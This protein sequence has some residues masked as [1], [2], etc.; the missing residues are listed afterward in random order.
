MKL[1]QVEFV[2]V[3]LGGFY[4]AMGVLHFILYLYNRHRKSFFVY[5]IGLILV[6]INFTLVKLPTEEGFTLTTQKA[7]DVISS[8]TNGVLLYFVSYYLFASTAPKLRKVIRVFA[9]FYSV[10]FLILLLSPVESNHFNPVFISLKFLSYLTAISICVFGLLKRTQNFYLIVSAT[11][12]L[13]ITEAF[14]AKDLFNFWSSGGVPYPIERNILI[15]VGYAVPFIAYSAYTSKDL[16]LTSK[17]LSRELMMNEK[18]SKEK[19]EQELVTRKLLEVQNVELER[20]VHERT[21][22]ISKQKEELAAQADKIIELDKI[23]SRFFANISHEFRTP[24]TLILGPLSKRLEK[25][26]D[27][28]E[29]QELSVMQRNASRLLNL[30]NQLLDLSKLEDGSLRLKVRLD[31]FQQFFTSVATQFSSAADARKINFMVHAVDDVDMYFDPDKLHKILTNLLSNAFKFTPSGGAITFAMKKCAS[32]T[33]F[34]SGFVEVL[35]M[36]TGPGIDPEHMPHIFNRFYQG[37]NGVTREYEGSGIGLALTKELVELHYGEIT[38]SSGAGK[39]TC[40]V[41]Q[42]PLGKEHL[43]EHE[44]NNKSSNLNLNA[45]VEDLSLFEDEL[46]DA[47]EDQALPKILIVEDNADMRHYLQDSLKTNFHIIE[48][49]DGAEGVIRAQSHVPD[50]IVSDLMMPKLDGLQLCVQIKSD[51]RTSHIPVILLTAKADNASRIEGFHL[52]ADDYIPKPFDVKELEVRITNLIDNRK[53]LQARYSHQLSLKPRDVQ[54]QSADEKFIKK[55]GDIIENHMDDFVFSV[56][57]LADEAA[58]SNVQLYRK[59]K[60]LTGKSPNDLIR[61]MRLERASSLLKQKGGN[62][63]DVAYQ[64]GFSNLSYFTK[65]FKEKYNQ[66]PSEILKE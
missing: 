64:V 21:R 42:L 5:S 26:T 29:I 41:V 59:L 50:L 8:A 34:P 62:V 22:Q 25:A 18:L 63:A 33:R 60:A 44:L 38:V 43:S 27:P 31:N 46:V 19:Y 32:S 10:G 16:A 4:L 55:V 58:M 20:S 56:E 11:L 57:I 9:A 36:D 1:T 51:E 52:G 30:V 48:A 61:S 37:D 66:L 47:N 23:K 53:K 12:L 65:C 39:G 6:S 13:V 28:Q 7:N 3:F 45:L 2:F 17:K 14:V 49:G 54:V 40:F 24:L 35:V 15:L